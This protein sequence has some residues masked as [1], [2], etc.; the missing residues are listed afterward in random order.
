MKG[1]QVATVS[2]Y[3]DAMTTYKPCESWILSPV[4]TPAK[5]KTIITKLIRIIG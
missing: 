5:H 4:H 1:E 2:T 3:E